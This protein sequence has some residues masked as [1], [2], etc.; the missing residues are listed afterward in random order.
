[1]HI[2]TTLLFGCY[3]TQKGFQKMFWNAFF[4]SIPPSAAFYLFTVIYLI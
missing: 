4:P 1:M 3:K 2:S